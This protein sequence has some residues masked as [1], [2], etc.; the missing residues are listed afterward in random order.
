MTCEHRAYLGSLKVRAT[1]VLLTLLATLPAYSREVAIPDTLAGQVL[2]AWLE[3]FNSGDEARFATY[4]NAYE[5]T[6]VLSLDAVMHLR[7]RTGGF[8]LVRIHKSSPLYI[9]F[10]LQERSSNTRHLGR[11]AV[12]GTNPPQVSTSGLRQIPSPAGIMGFEIDEADRERIISESITKLNKSYVFPETARRMEEALRRRQNRGEYDAITDGEK[13]AAL[14]TTHLQEVSRDKHLRVDFSPTGPPRDFLARLRGNR[15]QM[16]R[17]QPADCGFNRV[18]RLDGNVGYL[19]FDRFANPGE[20]GSAAIAAMNS[21]ADVDAIIFDL[22]DNGGG[23]PA[24]VALLSTYLFDQPTHLN[25]V[26][27]RQGSVR[28]EYWT[29]DELPGKRLSAVPAYVLT[30]SC[31]FSGAEEF[32]YNLK[33][34]KRAIIVGETT[35]G[36]AHSTRGERI[37][38]RYVIQVPFAQSINPITKTNWEGTGVEPDMKVPAADALSTALKLAAEKRTPANSAP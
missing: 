29:L 14:L 27:Y 16:D 7:A 10:L 12:T 20:C 13:F 17:S 31:T 28:L 1:L 30:S 21:L 24:M 18:E 4:Q 5:P 36:G 22:R 19:K 35:A 25:D 37:D 9:E 23:H 26:L 34:L 2:A 32:S 11:F 3:S 8:D 15:R 6:S 38:D 33:N